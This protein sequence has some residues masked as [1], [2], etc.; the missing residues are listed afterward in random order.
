[1]TTVVGDVTTER[2][3]G[4]DCVRVSV[5]DGL[6]AYAAVDVGPRVLFL[7]E[8]GGEN[9]LAELPDRTIDGP[10]G[11]YRLLGG[12][13]LWTAPEVPSRTYLPDG[14]RCRVEAAGDRITITAP[15]DGSGLER[16]MGLRPVE[17]GIEV[18]HLVTNVGSAPVEVASWAITQFPIGGT[19]FL[20]LPVSGS[21]E[22]EASHALV[23]W[24]YSRLDDPRLSF[25]SDHVVVT[26]THSPSPL[27]VGSAPG[28]GR[29]GYLRD[30]RLFTKEAP[31]PDGPLADR[32][33]ASQVYVG[34]EFLELETLG[35]LE[36]LPPG[37]STG[38]TEIWRVAEVDGPDEALALVLA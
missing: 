9:L 1:M 7:G 22:Y 23:L 34:P 35:L 5:N 14:E 33:A 26:A 32:G 13:R 11:P 18:N 38:H 37:E 21:S 24:P 20:P 28:S 19:A 8:P 31:V 10:A 17:G 25:G 27:K 12:H 29:L 4:H 2:H 30:G 36:R 6:V 15:D 16:G 3:L